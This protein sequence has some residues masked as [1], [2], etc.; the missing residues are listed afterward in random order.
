MQVANNGVK[1]AIITMKTKMQQ[2]TMNELKLHMAI[3]Y[4]HLKNLRF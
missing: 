2:V 3:L 4:Y 1:Y